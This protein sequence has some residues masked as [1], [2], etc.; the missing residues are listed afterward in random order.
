M[1]GA[2]RQ[3]RGGD[4]SPSEGLA[5]IRA[6]RARS[7]QAWQ[8]FR[9]SLPVETDRAPMD[10]IEGRRVALGYLQRHLE[11]LIPEGMSAE[12]GTASWRT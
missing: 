11:A 3:V 2:M 4:L 5:R 10:A 12:S 8:R 6:A 9:A 1:T 7:D